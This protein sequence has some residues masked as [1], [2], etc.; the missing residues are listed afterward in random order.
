MYNEKAPHGL[1][2]RYRYVQ[3]Q[4][5]T[6]CALTGMYNER[7]P[8]WAPSQVC[9]VTGYNHVQWRIEDFPGGAPTYYFAKF[10]IWIEK[11]AH[12]W[13]TFGSA[14]DVLPHRYVQWQGTPSAPY[15]VA[16]PRAEGKGV[17][18]LSASLLSDQ[19]CG[20]WEIEATFSH[21]YQ[22][23]TSQHF[24]ISAFLHGLDNVNKES[25]RLTLQIRLAS[26][27]CCN[28]S[29]YLSFPIFTCLLWLNP[30]FV[31]SGRSS[32]SQRDANLRGGH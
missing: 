31:P 23:S 32:I 11:G 21:P 4:G 22:S 25:T 17:R 16:D 10:W 19:H 2:Y 24:E 8:L 1:P 12:P 14:T 18:Y 7:V 20:Q 5:T 27:H 3:W 29:L 13:R 6:L 9:T 30:I 15:Q 26:S 28:S